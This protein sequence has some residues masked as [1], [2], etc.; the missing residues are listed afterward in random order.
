[1]ILSPA[2]ETFVRGA[3]IPLVVV[4]GTVIGVGADKKI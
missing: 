3:M 4:T 1:V 2:M